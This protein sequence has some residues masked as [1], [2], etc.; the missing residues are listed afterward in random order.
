M[1]G[2][3][4]EPLTGHI[5]AEIRGV[6]LRRVSPSTQKGLH[7]AWLEH[8]VLFFRDQRMTT[9]EHIDFGLLR[10]SLPLAA[11]AGIVSPWRSNPLR[12]LARLFGE[13]VSTWEREA[14][15]VTPPSRSGEYV[16]QVQIEY[17]R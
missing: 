16:L 10:L 1:A 11:N 8:K 3:D 6:D 7:E 14:K 9:E 13:L 17:W 12:Q 15:A 2:L 5:G 4:V